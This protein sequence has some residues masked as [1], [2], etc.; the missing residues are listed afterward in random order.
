MIAESVQDLTERHQ[1]N[2]N[3]KTY[4]KR[5]FSQPS[6]LLMTIFGRFNFVRNFYKSFAKR[7]ARSQTSTRLNHRSPYP[8]IFRDVDLE[9]ISN[10]L[11]KNGLYVGL[12]LPQAYLEKLVDFAAVTTCYGDKKY[13]YSFNVSQRLEAE[14]QY[15][16]QFHLAQYSQI[17]LNQFSVIQKIRSDSTLIDVAARYFGVEP[18][19]L[20]SRLFW[21]F[22]NN[23]EDYSMKQTNCYFHY[24]LDDYSCLRFFFYLT[25][26]TSSSGH[27]VCVQ[28]SHINKK[29][30]HILSRSHIERSDDEIMRHYGSDKVISIDGQAGLGFIE[31]S[32]CFHKATRPLH[33]DRLMLQVTFAMNDYGF[34]EPF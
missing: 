28:G 1:I 13:E 7:R 14:K 12:T 20:T 23:L 30:A 22:T 34:Y 9:N 26:V 16:R 4:Y 11:N 2:H 17:D 19:Y 21:T 25:D 18:V 3:P 10:T 32:M 29:I 8:S 24:D 31:D 27:H 33:R 6:C 15:G 5:R